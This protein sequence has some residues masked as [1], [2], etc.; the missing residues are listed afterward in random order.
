[1][2]RTFYLNGKMGKLFGKEW[3]LNAA[4]IREGMKGIDVQR[5]N[6]LTKYLV[7]CTERGIKFTVQRGED[8]LDYENLQMDLGKDDIIITPVPAGSIGKFGKLIIGIALVATGLWLGSLAGAAT[9]AQAFGL[10]IASAAALTV[11]GFLTSSAISEYFAPKPPTETEEGYLFDGP[12]NVIKQ[13]I[14]VPLCYGQLEIGGTPMNFGFTNNITKPVGYTF[15]GKNGAIPPN[16]NDGWG[17]YCFNAT[18]DGND[19]ADNRSESR[20]DSGFD[21]IIG[22]VGPTP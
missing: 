5:D 22:I 4:T 7:D 11:G 14:P 16:S 12:S 6:K 20:D 1:M 8:F 9:G 18:D 2:T 3:K 21:S 19:G 13:G 10:Y 17:R 15:A